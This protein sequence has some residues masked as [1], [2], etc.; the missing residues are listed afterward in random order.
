MRYLK[1]IQAVIFRFKPKLEFLVLHRTP[2]YGGFWQNLSGGVEIGETLIQALK[3]E[4]EEETG[5]KGDQIKRIIK[6]VHYY[7][8]MHRDEKVK[9]WVFGVEVD[10]K[11]K[12]KLSEEHDAYKWC[13]AEKAKSLLKW[14]ENKEAIDKILLR[15][16]KEK[17]KEVLGKKVEVI[18]DR[19]LGSKH[20]RYHFNYP[21][22]YG[23]V[24][25]LKAP[26]GEYLDAY[27]LGVSK[28]L[29]I[30]KGKVIAIIERSDDNE[31]KLVVVPEGKN[32][33]RKEIEKRIEFQEKW[34]NTRII[35][36]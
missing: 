4:I 32:Y 1:E 7:E 24:K 27:V 8:W 6:G 31:D 11:V 3:R 5:I 13:E 25:E 2:K 16:F 28:P 33:S 14:K 29:E 10:P 9:E 20:P 30:F 35:M 21:V 19:P 34:F 36:S 12:V 15:I 17:I 26:D 23:H 18:I 22:N